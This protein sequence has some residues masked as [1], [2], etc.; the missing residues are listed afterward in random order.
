MKIIKIKM[1]A[2]APCN[3]G[4]AE[5]AAKC[6]VMHGSNTSTSIGDELVAKCT[7]LDIL[8]QNDSKLN[9]LGKDFDYQE[10]LKKKILMR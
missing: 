1:Q 9:P 5:T 10:E 8:H 2:R 3:H 4:Q 6:P 7:N